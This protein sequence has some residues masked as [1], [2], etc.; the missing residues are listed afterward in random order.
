MLPKQ[1]TGVRVKNAP[2]D[3]AMRKLLSEGSINVP[4]VF[5]G[6]TGQH[7]SDRISVLV[8]R[9]TASR[10]QDAAL[11]SL[12]HSYR[13]ELFQ[14]PFDLFA[15]RSNPISYALLCASAGWSLLAAEAY[16]I[17]KQWPLARIMLLGSA[18]R[19]LEDHLYDETLPPDCSSA[20]FAM[21]FEARS[22]DLWD[23]SIGW[24]H[25]KADQPRVPEESDPT[26]AEPSDLLQPPVTAPRDLPSD[27]TR[28][29]THRA[30]SNP[31][32]LAPA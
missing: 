20:I 8:A 16:I 22:I 32:V 13:V 28:D 27:E 18:P 7:K 2:E 4:A 5:Q 11:T 24:N 6:N 30:D 9:R 26:K 31:F 21:A 15:S 3:L 10:L 12:F 25:R 14:D 23:R 17:R 19:E 1:H 29:L